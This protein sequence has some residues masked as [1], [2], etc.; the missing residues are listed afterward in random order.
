M[1]SYRP[2]ASRAYPGREETVVRRFIFAAASAGGRIVRELLHELKPIVG[3]TTRTRCIQ[4]AVRSST[5][6]QPSVD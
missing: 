6:S 1:Y 3:N 5:G 4:T 2:A